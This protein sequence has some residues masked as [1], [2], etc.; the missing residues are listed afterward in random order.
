MNVGSA[1]FITATTEVIS[2][3]L[4][5]FMGGASV[6]VEYDEFCVSGWNVVH[7]VYHDYY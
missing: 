1:A 5:G 7:V 4:I 6:G 2:M 3:L